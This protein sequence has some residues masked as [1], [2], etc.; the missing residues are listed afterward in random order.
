MKQLNT[1]YSDIII[2][3]NGITSQ[4]LAL[5]LSKILGNR[6]AITIIDKEKNDSRTSEYVRSL[7]VSL[8][9]VNLCKSMGIWEL[10][11]PHTHPI[12][13]I[14]ISHSVSDEEKRSFLN[15]DNRVNDEV[16]SYI[17][18]ERVLRKVISEETAKFNNINLIHTNIDDINLGDDLISIKAQDQILTSKLVVAGDGRKSIVK[19]LLKIKSISW[20]YNQ[21]ALS[22]L[23]KHKANND[24][25]AIENFLHTGPIALLPMGKRI[26][27]VIWSVQRDKIHE[28]KNICDGDL[29]LS[30]EKQFKSYIGEITA[31]DNSSFF[32]LNFS[33]AQKL[34]VKRCAV[35]GDA[36]HSIHP[37]AGQGT[38]LGLRDIISLSDG[39]IEA[40][41]YGLDIGSINNLQEYQRLRM[42]DILTSALAYDGINRLYSNSIVGLNPIKD[43]AISLAESIPIIKKN[44]VKGGSGLAIKS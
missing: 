38:N 36:A 2:V 8:S 9:T 31:I 20:D 6:L 3:G 5:R 15:L 10:I 33:I 44:L 13:K 42:P 22:C 14:I 19:K 21:T 17:I 37:L 12:R 41:K 18:D 24:N 34:Y 32:E 16:A 7:S 27:S 23:I 29:K 4:F 40:V 28:I 30:I 35:M 39:I 25:I 11:E 1:V 26:S 43:L